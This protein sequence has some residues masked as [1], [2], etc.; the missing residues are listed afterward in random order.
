MAVLTDVQ[1]ASEVSLRELGGEPGAPSRPTGDAVTVVGG[2]GRDALHLLTSDGRVLEPRGA[3]WQDTGV[4]ADLL[5]TQ[6]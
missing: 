3:G 2:A 1:G 6:R 4:Q 5:A